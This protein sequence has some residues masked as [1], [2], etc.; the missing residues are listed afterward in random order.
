M[1]VQRGWF[2]SWSARYARVPWKSQVVVNIVIWSASFVIAISP[3]GVNLNLNV[4]VG[5]VMV[6][7]RGRIESV[8]EQT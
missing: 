5:N 3:D 8:P 7:W 6:G 4:V 2:P 1:F